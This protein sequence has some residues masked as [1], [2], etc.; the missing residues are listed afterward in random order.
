MGLLRTLLLGDLGNLLDIKDNQRS[1]ESAR[2][3]LWR[4]RESQ[5]DLEER[6]RTLEREGEQMQVFIAALL[7]T[8]K[9]EDL[10]TEEQVA[11]MATFADAVDGPG[12][13]D[14]QPEPPASDRPVG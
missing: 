8:L 2:S 9:H 14:G 4:T 12:E 11:W 5:N 7:A 6:V 1:L 10:L 3:E 13:G